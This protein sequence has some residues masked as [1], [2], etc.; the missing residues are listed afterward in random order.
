VAIDGK[1]VRPVANGPATTSE[2]G[3]N[4]PCPPMGRRSGDYCFVSSLDAV[5][6]SLAH[7]ISSLRTAAFA[8]SRSSV[9]ST[10]MLADLSFQ[11]FRNQLRLI[12]LDQRT[13]AIEMISFERLR[14]PDRHGD[15]VQ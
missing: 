10:G 9:R 3:G 6:N 13:K 1:P 7:F 15:A 8:V 5:A 12:A 14:S 4:L 2:D 11:M